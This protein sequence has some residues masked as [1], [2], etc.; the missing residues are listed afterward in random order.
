MSIHFATLLHWL[1]AYKY[2]ILVPVVFIEG[3]IATIIAGSLAASG[4]LNF[5]LAYLL[6]VTS[7]VS[8]DSMYYSLGRFGRKAFVNRWGHRL[9]LPPERMEK[10]GAH[11]DNHAA[12]T[13]ILGKLAFSFEIPFLLTA[14]MLRVPYLRFL[15]YITIA[16]LPKSLGLMLIGYFF[17]FSLTK[18]SHDVTFISHFVFMLGSLIVVVIAAHVALS[19]WARRSNSKTGKA[20][21]RAYHYV[22][23]TE[24]K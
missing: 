22:R 20:Y 17:G 9:G 13:L 4:Q 7:D 5:G 21:L 8:A 16:A 1:I 24:Q 2:A 11:F 3:P 18:L 10:F 23:R 19:R 15:A 6:I 14:G 12:R